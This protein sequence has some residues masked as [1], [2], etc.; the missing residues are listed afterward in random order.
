MSTKRLGVMTAALLAAACFPALADSSNQ[1][2]Q[3]GTEDDATV[4]QTSMELSP[5]AE[6]SE[7]AGDAA[8]Y[9]QPVGRNG[10]HSM[11]PTAPVAAGQSAGDDGQW[12]RQTGEE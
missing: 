8:G 12:I 4:I 2:S 6:N 1:Q 3:T 5:A 7:A 11:H 10:S 9:I